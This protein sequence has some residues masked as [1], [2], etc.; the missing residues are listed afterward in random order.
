MM[1]WFDK[2]AVFT[3]AYAG[4]AGLCL[5]MDRHYADLHGRGKEPP[6]ATRRRLQWGGWLALA[7]SLAWAV[8]VDGGALGLLFWCGGLTGAAL[9]L[10]LLLPYAPRHAARLGVAAGAATAL[11]CLSLPL[12]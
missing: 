8:K 5:A 10:V 6:P 7:I 9:L 3:A 1:E 4:M 2:L 12:R 11:A